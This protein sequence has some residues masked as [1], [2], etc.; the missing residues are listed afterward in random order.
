MNTSGRRGTAL[1]IPSATVDRVVDQLVA[2]G[3]ISKG[4]LGVGMQPVR[5][6]NNLKTA[7]N[8]TSATGVIVVNVE[9][10]GLLTMQACC[11]AM[12]W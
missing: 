6:P 11:L 10:S 2:K 1:T 12:F 3:R 4:Y 5:L 9:S 7:L 8:L